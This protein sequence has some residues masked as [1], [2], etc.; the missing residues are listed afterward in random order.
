MPSR[1][2]RSQPRFPIVTDSPSGGS[3]AAGA[4]SILASV[5]R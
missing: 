4:N 1:F 5:S 3:V 2:Q